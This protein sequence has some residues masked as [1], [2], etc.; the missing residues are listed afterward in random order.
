MD[1]GGGVPPQVNAAAPPQVNGGT[2]GPVGGAPPQI[3]RYL[4]GADS[5][6]VKQVLQQQQR[7][8]PKLPPVG[9]TAHTIAQAG[10]PAQQYAVM[11]AFRRLSDAASAHA[12]VSLTGAGKH[13]PSL[14]H[15]VAFANKKFEYTPSPLQ[16]SFALKGAGKPTQSAT[17]K[18]TQNT[19]R[20]GGIQ[21]FDD[22]GAVED[23]GG[24]TT[25]N[26]NPI[27]QVNAA[28][29]NAPTSA[30]DQTGFQTPADQTTGLPITMTV[31][32]LQNG[33]SAQA[34]TDSSGLRDMV[35]ATFENWVGKPIA[36][37]ENNFKTRLANVREAWNPYA[38][39]IQPGT[40]GGPDYD[41]V[42]ALKNSASA[43]FGTN[44]SMAGQ[45]FD[46]RLQHNAV[47]D[48]PPPAPGGAPQKSSLDYMTGA[49]QATQPSSNNP[50][51]QPNVGTAET[52]PAGAALMQG[53]QNND[54]TIVRAGGP[55]GRP[56][57]TQT[58]LN[59]KPGTQPIASD[60]YNANIRPI[61]SPT[62]QSQ[63]LA[64]L[65][66]EP[67]GGNPNLGQ[68]IVRNPMSGER[69]YVAPGT[70]LAHMS[71][72]GGSGQGEPVTSGPQAGDIVAG[73][74][75]PQ[76]TPP[77]P[78]AHGPGIDYPDESQNFGKNIGPNAPMLPN[79]EYRLGHP[80]AT[81]RAINQSQQQSPQRPRQIPQQPQPQTQLRQPQTQQQALALPPQ[82]Q[83]PQRGRIYQTSKGRAMWTGQ[84]FMPVAG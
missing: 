63:A 48:N 33:K 7:Q 20:G 30:P 35:H 38:D 53:N 58:Y 44:T 13:P 3:M 73:P 25:P 27:S 75:A 81:Q 21:A 10:G 6:P 47:A 11:Q 74:G 39:Y 26:S 23:D 22:G 77:N 2:P 68:T 66:A 49:S 50:S 43:W 62:V 42:D 14:P 16:I 72:F 79:A 41:I 12:K 56:T 82:G 83:Q 29:A 57:T 84:Q 32:D 4:T 52:I 64:P 31:H 9:R 37:L 70:D 40:E 17:R 8:D 46:P 15:A 60:K 55:G 19:Y 69:S 76:N 59:D 18:P 51:Q 78:P 24:D 5:A 80:A 34:D 61:N 45:R 28:D 65:G 1:A 71:Q 54:M 36:Q 67:S